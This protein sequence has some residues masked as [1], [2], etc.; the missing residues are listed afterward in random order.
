MSLSA[1]EALEGD[2]EPEDVAVVPETGDLDL[3]DREDE[4]AMS[5]PAAA[6]AAE[7]NIASSSL[8]DDGNRRSRSCDCFLPTIADIRLKYFFLLL[9]LSAAVFPKFTSAYI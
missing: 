9:D 7:G 6:A 2:D 8:A 4:P 3:L 1:C 5:A